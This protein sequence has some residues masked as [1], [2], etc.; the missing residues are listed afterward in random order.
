MIDQEAVKTIAAQIEQSRK[1]A[2]FV[3][4]LVVNPDIGR[5]TEHAPVHTPFSRTPDWWPVFWLSYGQTFSQYTEEGA[6]NM[7]FRDGRFVNQPLDSVKSQ[8]LAILGGGGGAV[9][10]APEPDPVV[11]N[12]LDVEE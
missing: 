12:V 8:L 10:V 6:K 1:N 5:P 9:L 4:S 2:D 7:L 3:G 11:W